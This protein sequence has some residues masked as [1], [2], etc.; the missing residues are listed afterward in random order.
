MPGAGPHEPAGRH[1][2][3]ANTPFQ[4]IA[5]QRGLGKAD[6]PWPLFQRRRL[7]E[8][9]PDARQVAGV[10]ALAGLKLDEGER[11]EG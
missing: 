3:L 5:A 2:L 6:E 7:S 11:E 8:Q 4:E 1:R 9:R 10:V